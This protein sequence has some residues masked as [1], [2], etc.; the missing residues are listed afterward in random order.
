[1]NDYVVKPVNYEEL[2]NKIEKTTGRIFK[3]VKI[4]KE[5]DKVE[6]EE[7]DEVIDK[8][9]LFN[10]FDGDGKLLRTI[11]ETFLYDCPKI[12]S[13]IYQSLA[14][15][16]SKA[17]ERAAHTVKGTVS[18]FAAKAAFDTALKLETMAEHNNLASTKEVYYRLAK[19]MEKLKKALVT[20]I[21]TIQ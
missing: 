8:N 15:N 11:I 2:F 16:D 10:R 17:L 21:S 19:E 5:L 18:I 20:I 14:D 13:D 1:M 4:D 12:M 6:V 3:Q 9:Q 7:L